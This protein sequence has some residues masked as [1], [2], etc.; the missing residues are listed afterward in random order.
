MSKS[1][2]KYCRTSLM[3]LALA[4]TGCLVAT[5][6]TSTALWGQETL[7]LG[8]DLQEAAP[9]AQVIPN[10]SVK[11]KVK[12]GSERLELTV[13]ESRVM[14]FPYE[15]PKVLVNNPDLVKVVP[16]SP[17]SIQVSAIKPGVT[18]LNFF[19]ME[20]QVTAVDLVILGDVKELDMTLKSLFPDSD[21]RLRPLAN[22]LY[23]SGF[24]PKA[25][26]VAKIERVAKTFFPEI[27]ND[28]TVGGVHKVQLHVK[29]MEVS[30]T[31]LRDQGFDWQQISSGS[32][33]GMNS[34]GMLG[35]G[36]SVNTAATATNIQFGVIDG[37]NRFFGFLQFLQRKQLAKLL[38]EPTLTTVS[39]RPASFNSGGQ[40]PI[41]VPQALG[42]TT[43]EYREFGTQIDFVPVIL[44]NGNIRL[45]VLAQVT[46]IDPS[47]AVAVGSGT[48]PGFRS[49]RADTAQEM[50]AGQTMAI[51][52]MVY[53]RLDSTIRGVPVLSD[54]PWAGA[55]FRR[56]TETNNEVE[57]IIMVTPEFTDA[58]D[59][60]EVPPC[61]PG[62]NTTSPTDGEMFIR[63]YQEVPRGCANGNCP[64]GM[65]PG[66][67][68]AETGVNAYTNAPSQQSS[69][70]QATANSADVRLAT[71]PAA[72]TNTSSTKPLARSSGLTVTRPSSIGN[73][74]S[75]SDNSPS[76]GPSLG[77]ASGVKAASGS[78][79]VLIGPQGYDSLR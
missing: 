52:G 40:I 35:A 68:P 17:T 11:F 64:T 59:P 32:Y 22:G 31:K 37:S 26:T 48:V 25:D 56:T 20:D 70:R 36:G 18:Q 49:R 72:G 54:L 65:S 7:P 69:R 15:V 44:G 41:A 62:Q 34:A 66:N 27:I 60:T 53:N 42:V 47:L 78:Q 6:A 50:K 76:V 16:I 33:V 29:V 13:N 21:I 12:G 58:M 51:A 23:M 46:E 45:E 2:L 75:V 71:R 73:S 28:L 38:S 57:L 5:S 4:A 61:G 74:G 9:Q 24:V 55:A 8:G 10:A 30:R 19:N 39:G 3:R 43:I 67:T 63:G 1:L 77:S 79:P 14:E